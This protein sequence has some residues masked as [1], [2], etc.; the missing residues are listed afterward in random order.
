MGASRESMPFR[1]LL[2]H[3]SMDIPAI[4][5]LWHPKDSTLIRYLATI[6]RDVLRQLMGLSITI[7]VDETAI[8]YLPIS[9]FVT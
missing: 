9:E 3:T 6:Q 5:R 1:S 4:S 8:D 7:L 2:S